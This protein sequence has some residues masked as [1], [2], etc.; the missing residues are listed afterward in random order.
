VVLAPMFLFFCCRSKR[1]RSAS[2]GTSIFP[3]VLFFSTFFLQCD[4]LSVRGPLVPRPPGVYASLQ[5]SP[6][7]TLLPPPPIFWLPFVPP[8]G[9]FWLISQASALLLR[10]L[11]DPF[12]LASC[13]REGYSPFSFPL[14]SRLHAPCC[15]FCTSIDFR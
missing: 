10:F 5:D 13:R 9:R 11:L 15:D 14:N 8:E 7:F 2:P 3:D 4:G 1:S 12:F 6:R